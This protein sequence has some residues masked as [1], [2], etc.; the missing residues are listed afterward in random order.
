MKLYI[1]WWFNPLLSDKEHIEQANSTLSSGENG[2][3]R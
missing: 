3:K 2:D 1:T